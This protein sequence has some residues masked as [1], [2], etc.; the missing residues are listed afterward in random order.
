[1]NVNKFHV[2][3]FLMFP[4]DSF[5]TIYGGPC[6]RNLGNAGAQQYSDHTIKARFLGYGG[7]IR[8]GYMMDK[9]LFFTNL[10]VFSR[11]FKV[12][13]NQYTA[14]NGGWNIISQKKGLT[15]FVPGVGFEYLLT[16]CMALGI[17]ANVQLY[18]SKTF[19]SEGT[20]VTSGLGSY[21]KY[22]SRR[23]SGLLTASYKFN[24]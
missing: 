18:P 14:V 7:G 10:G 21:I 9:V 13:W 2:G 17:V 20:T 24:L 6:R 11:W 19:V 12:T 15:A 4:G 23:L 1:M 5:K 8:L 22:Q 3:A 16:S